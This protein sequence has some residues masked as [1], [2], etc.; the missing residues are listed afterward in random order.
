MSM[1]NRYLVPAPSPDMTLLSFE[2]R[3][4]VLTHK[5]IWLGFA[6]SMIALSVGAFLCFCFK[7]KPFPN[8]RQRRKTQGKLDAE[9]MLLRR[10]HLQELEKAT[11]NFSP[12][13]LVGTGAFGN[14][15]RGTF[16][17]HGTFAIKKARADS[18][19]STEEF[20][21]EVRLLSKVRHRNLVSLVGFCEEPGRKGEKILVYEY[22]PNGSLLDYII[23]RGGR[24]LSWRERVNI[25]IG[26]AKGITHLHEGLKPSIIHRDIKPSNIL[27][28]E[29][30]EAKVS[31]FGLVKSGPVGDQS[32]V[33]SQIKGTPGYLDPAYCSSCHL[34]PFSDVYSFGVILLQ[35]VAARPAVD[36]TR[37]RSN[38]HIIEWA[39]PSLEQGNVEEILDANLLLDPDCNLEMMLKMGQLGL[40]CVAKVPKQRP[41]MT[42]VWQE[43]E[44]SL[45]STDNSIYKE[46][47]NGPGISI[48]TSRRSTDHDYS[49][50]FVSED[51]VR[52]QR[53]HVEMDG[54]SFQSTSLRCFE[55]SS[56]MSIDIDK[57]NQTGISE[58]ANAYEDMDISIPRD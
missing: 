43:L 12:D 19:T 45:Y 6:G 49:Q 1:A 44:S 57:K 26:A 14:V 9:K 18:Y 42:H 51:S 22:V 30:F 52:L 3:N 16:D 40:R 8:F 7:T 58:E 37:S 11:E 38:Y 54:L 5:H 50:S 2:V 46:P 55:A 35:L 27:I 24:S 53:F 39:R 23:G 20:K 21:N 41:T 28:G 29:E 25:A 34:S 47:S 32:H 17:E 33:S 48:R 4:S 13:C 15:Y 31:D 36:S 56:V 10:F